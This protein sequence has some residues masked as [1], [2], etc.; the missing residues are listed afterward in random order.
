MRRHTVEASQ[1]RVDDIFQR[2]GWYPRAP[3]RRHTFRAIYQPHGDNGSVRFRFDHMPLRN[4]PLQQPVVRF[5]EQGACVLGQVSE[6]V[7][8][9]GGVLTTHETCPQLALRF[10][11]INVIRPYKRLTHFDDGGVE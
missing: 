5:W 6:D 3:A 2:V 9:R 1:Q 7:T 8:G 10:Q 11:Q 4:S